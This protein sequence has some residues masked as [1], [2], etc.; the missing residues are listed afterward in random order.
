M[1]LIKICLLGLSVSTQMT[2]TQFKEHSL[3]FKLRKGC[4]FV[5]FIQT[6]PEP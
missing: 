4:V 3:A 1:I 6:I 5:S 2:D